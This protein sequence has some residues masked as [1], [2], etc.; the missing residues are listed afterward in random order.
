MD[1]IFAHSS[2]LPPAG[3]AVI[4]ISGP[5]AHRAG[6]VLA[7]SLPAAR[8]TALRRL[9]D[10]GG[11]VLDDA[12][13]L[14]F[15]APASATGEDVVELHCHG[16]RA[17][18]RA[19]LRSLSELSYLREAAP[20]EFTRRAFEHGRIDLTEAEGLA[21]LLEAETESQRRAALA[22]AEGSL[23]SQVEKWRQRLIMLSA[24]AEA[25]IDYVG[26]ADETAA[27]VDE[28]TSAAA[29]LREELSEW[30]ARPRAERLKTG[31]KVVIAGPP[32]SGKSSLLNALSEEDRAIMTDV[33]GTTRDV[34]EVPVSWHGV[35][36][37]LID[38]AGLRA[39][40]DTV[41]RIGVER[42]EQQLQSADIL[43]WT[44][45][46]SE[47]PAHLNA[48]QLFTKA[49][50]SAGSS[51]QL[52]GL[53]VSSVTKEGLD[54]LRGWLLS[55]ARSLLPADRSIAINERQARAIHECAEALADVRGA[56]LVL[57]AEALRAARVG[58][59][60]V[61]GATGIEEVLDA[62]FGRFCLGK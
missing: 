27:D 36:L 11:E 30:L 39:S 12:L 45:L 7:G 59:D 29:S 6:E 10:G 23:R 17:V 42:T 34:I 56:D 1:T 43:L 14:R 38:T 55:A 5:D 22:M 40:D 48:L 37:V 21:D 60:R 41:E 32:N 50:L 9:R 51:E 57:I 2:G 62:L 54:A 52:G 13:V 15:D 19:V 46:E 33:A 26:D 25:A 8:Q 20:G 53:K 61:T 4:R 49:D 44:G 16:S 24:Q 35:P 3:I 28:L 18:V 58:L 31:I 47:R